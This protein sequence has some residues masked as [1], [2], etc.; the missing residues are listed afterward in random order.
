MPKYD[1]AH[2]KFNRGFVTFPVKEEPL[3]KSSVNWLTAI[4]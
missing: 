4:V 3:L 2:P 1:F